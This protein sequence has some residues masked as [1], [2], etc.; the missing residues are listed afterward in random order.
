MCANEYG[1]PKTLFSSFSLTS[2]F[3]IGHSLEREH[4]DARQEP[5]SGEP[6]TYNQTEN[7]STCAYPRIASLGPTTSRLITGQKC[8]KLAFPEFNRFPL[9]GQ[10][11]VA[12]IDADDACPTSK[13]ASSASFR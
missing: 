1:T 13:A 7:R 2:F 10:K 5:A 8:D 4:R 3:V 6:T 11:I 12:L 9:L